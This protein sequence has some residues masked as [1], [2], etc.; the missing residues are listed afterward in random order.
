MKWEVYNRFTSSQKEEYNYKFGSIKSM[1]NQQILVLIYMTIFLC[2]SY[3]V[4]L[5]SFYI[6]YLEFGM[7]FV[8]DDFNTISKTVSIVLGVM[9]LYNLYILFV[10]I[11][12]WLY[13]RPI[14]LKKNMIKV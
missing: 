8:F 5:L 9:L 6:G 11:Y 1:F 7:P 13:K 10:I 12:K 14:W 2:L 3:S 4:S